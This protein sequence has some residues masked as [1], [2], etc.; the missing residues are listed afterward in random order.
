MNIHDYKEP[1][2]KDGEDRLEMIFARQRE[3]VRKYILIEVSTGLRR[4]ENCPVDLDVPADQ[5]QLKDE[6]WRIS[7]ELGEAFDARYALGHSKDHV[8]EEFADSVHFFIELCILSGV[9]TGAKLMTLIRDTLDY[10]WDEIVGDDLLMEWWQVADA[11]RTSETKETADASPRV[12]FAQMMGCFLWKLGVLMNN[13]KCKPW[14][15]TPILTDKPQYLRDLAD[16]AV[17]FLAVGLAFGM[18][19]DD[20]F[21]CYFRKSEVNKFR[22]ETNY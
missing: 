4:S 12:Q 1:E 5:L 14:K 9:D 2:V 22:Q 6:A 18:Q 17:A 3:L 21:S 10:E 19:S 20:I 8:W 16:A 7:E 13:L 15:Q 11:F